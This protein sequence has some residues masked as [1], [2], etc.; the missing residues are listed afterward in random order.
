MADMKAANATSF[1]QYKSMTN[2]VSD[3]L[4]MV[5]SPLLLMFPHCAAVNRW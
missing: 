5:T 1:D 2:A 4:K 3:S